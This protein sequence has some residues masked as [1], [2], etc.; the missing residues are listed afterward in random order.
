MHKPKKTEYDPDY[1]TYVSLVAENDITG[2][3]ERQPTEL[4]NLF[5]ET[6]EEKGAYAYAEGK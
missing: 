4:R 5:A 6:A 3:L 1:E 2:V